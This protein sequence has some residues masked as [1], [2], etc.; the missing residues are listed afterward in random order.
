M[1][2]FRLSVDEDQQ[3]SG[4]EGPRSRVMASSDP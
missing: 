2:F 3:N 1:L 4:S